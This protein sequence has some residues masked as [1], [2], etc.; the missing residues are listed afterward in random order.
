MGESLNIDKNEVLRYLGHKNQ[1]ID[2]ELDKLIDKCII[3]LEQVAR[4]LYT[5]RVFDIEVT[6]DLA[7]KVVG[8][9]LV[10]RGK[11][12]FSHLKNAKKCAILAATL[13]VAVDNK[14]RI[15]G[16]TDMTKSFILDACATDRIEKVCD[17]AEAEIIAQASEENYKTNFRYSPGYG[18]LPIDIQGEII[19]ILN[20]N[21]TIGL[22]T[23]ATS[24][25][26]PRKS[27][28]AIVGFL[29]KDVEVAKKRNC[30]NCNLRKTCN[31]RREGGSCGS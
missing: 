20:A 29:E 1:D 10:L 28:T 24:I 13:G 6:D 8:T 15:T 26:I 16:K 12:I 21:K 3:E 17:K 31:F 27:V 4:P 14:I 19:S 11:D 7:I 18:D 22:T 30:G 9:N 2:E 23:T 25:L 5:Y